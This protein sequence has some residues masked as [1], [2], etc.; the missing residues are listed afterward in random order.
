[1]LGRPQL[2]LVR[3]LLL[4]QPQLVRLSER[5]DSDFDFLKVLSTVLVGIKQPKSKR[6]GQKTTAGTLMATVGGTRN[7]PFL[8]WA[9]GVSKHFGCVF[10][11]VCVIGLSAF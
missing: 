3:E 8:P 2:Q 7:G 5:V 4:H 1:M 11:C 10:C 9:P 6:I